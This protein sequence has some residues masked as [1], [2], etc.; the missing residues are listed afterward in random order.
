MSNTTTVLAILALLGTGALLLVLIGAAGIARLSGRAGIS[1]QALI[2]ACLLT[3]GYCVLLIGVG[4]TG[5]ER[6]LPVGALKYFCEMDC[7][8]SNAVVKVSMS[9]TIGDT[10]AAGQFYLVTVKTWFDPSTTSP[11]TAAPL[12]GRN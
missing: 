10:R 2:G 11:S 9:D 4:L 1:R 8:V 12:R 3:F 6:V 7:H 5:G